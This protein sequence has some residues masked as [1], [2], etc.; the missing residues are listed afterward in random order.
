MSTRQNLSFADYNYVGRGYNPG[1]FGVNQHRGVP[2]DFV[3]KADLGAPALASAAMYMNSAT[4]TNLPNN[5][6]KTYTAATSGTAPLDASDIPTPA[7]LTMYD[8]ANYLVWA[9]DV[10]RNLSVVCSNTGGTT[11]ACT[12]TVTGFDLYRNP[13]SELFT[14]TAT[15]SPVTVVGKKAFK[16]IYSIAIYAAGNSTTNVVTVGTGS[17]LGLPYCLTAKSD[18]LGA[19]FDTSAANTPAYVVKDTTNPATTS[20][21]DVRGTA[22]SSDTFNGAKHFYVWYR[23]ADPNSSQGLVG[24]DPYTFTTTPPFNPNSKGY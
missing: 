4:T 11:V 24:V 18:I 14:V 22:T 1:A 20:T 19:F 17:L 5:A 15:T 6:T 13:V 12:V 21:G 3:Y 23:I 8:S 16:Y 10:P 9:N 2:V 7:T